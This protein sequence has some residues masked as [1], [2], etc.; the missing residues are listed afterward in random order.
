M[1]NLETL[2]G[3]KEKYNKYMREYREKN[4]EK[5][6]EYKRIYNAIWRKNNGYPSEKKY[7]ERNPEKYKAQQILNQS[8]YKG[9]IKRENCIICNSENAQAH[10]EDY[11][12]PHD[13]IW[14][15]SIHHKQ[16]HMSNLKEV[17]KNKDEKI[18]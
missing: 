5:M 11:T 7:K 12:K 10:H 1:P 13:V 2:N 6:R 4:A 3:D 14:I 16:V 18:Q 9:K 17:L 15:C 8:I